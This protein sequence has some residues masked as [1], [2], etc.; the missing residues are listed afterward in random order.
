MTLPPRDIHSACTWLKLL[1]IYL[2]VSYTTRKVRAENLSSFIWLC[3]P[4]T[5]SNEEAL[6]KF[7]EWIRWKCNFLMIFLKLHLF[8]TNAE[9]IPCLKNRPSQTFYSTFFSEP[10]CCLPLV[11]WPA[12]EAS[13]TSFF[14]CRAYLWNDRIWNMDRS[15]E[16]S[17]LFVSKRRIWDIR[18][19]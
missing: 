8:V 1:H 9:L 5:W 14:Y 3:V 12:S 2:P 11:P 18:R 10:I 19:C 6:N 16:Y 15:R 13:I 17:V 4:S 7:I